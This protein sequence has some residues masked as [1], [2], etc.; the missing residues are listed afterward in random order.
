MPHSAIVINKS[1]SLDRVLRFLPSNYTANRSKSG[2]IVITGED[3]AGWTMQD[4][5][6][7]RLLSGLI[8]I[9]VQD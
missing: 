8:T 9:M 4:Y 3:I 6:Q 1:E 5:V 2:H 7:P